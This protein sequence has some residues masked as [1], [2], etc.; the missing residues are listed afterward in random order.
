[1][2]TFYGKYPARIDDKGRIVLPAAIRRDMPAG[3]DMRFVIKKSI[4]DSC[5]EM[6]T[7]EVWNREMEIR[8]SLESGSTMSTSR[9]YSL[10][11]NTWS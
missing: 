1:M 11:N 6:Y 4:Y 3:G 10:Q 5:L 7:Y 8:P 9:I 2:V